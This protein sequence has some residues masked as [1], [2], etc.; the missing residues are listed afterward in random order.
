MEERNLPNCAVLS[1]SFCITLSTIVFL[2]FYFLLFTSNADYP[3]GIANL[4][5]VSLISQVTLADFG[6]PV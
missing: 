5:S 6:Y 4:F 1:S 3:F 2:L